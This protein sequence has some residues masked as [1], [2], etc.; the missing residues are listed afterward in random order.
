MFIKNVISRIFFKYLGLLFYTGAKDQMMIA[1]YIQN[2]VLKFKVSCGLQIILFSDP[3][4]RVDTG[5]QQSIRIKLDLDIQNPNPDN[6][7]LCS[8]VIQLNDTHTMSGKYI[9]NFPKIEN[10]FLLKNDFTS[11]CLLLMCC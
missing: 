2:G 4:D 5:F 7:T 6:P 1:A 3:R 9:L 8:T 11:F 10:L